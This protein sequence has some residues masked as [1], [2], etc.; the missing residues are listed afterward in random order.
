MLTNLFLAACIASAPTPLSVEF[1]PEIFFSG[2]TH[3]QGTLYL[4]GRSPRR[5]VVQSKGEMLQ[6]QL[7]RLEQTVTFA[8]G[9]AESRTFYLRRLDRQRYS[10]KLSD[11]PGPVAAEVRGNSLHLRYLL[12]RPAIYMEQWLYLQPDGK[13]VVNTGKVKLLGVE[14]AH[15]SETIVCAS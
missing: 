11:A 1:R 2:V 14:L 13:T 5:F 10:A 12:R 3:G 7:F 4:R 9:G 15:I 8:N 6:S